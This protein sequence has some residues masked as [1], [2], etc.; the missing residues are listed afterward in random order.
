[1]TYLLG[2]DQGGTKTTAIVGD[3]SGHILGIGNSFGAVHS[4]HG[5][6]R[7]MEASKRA[8][9]EAMDSAGLTYDDIY[10]IYGGVS[11]MDWEYERALIENAMRETFPVK[12]IRVVNDCIIAMRSA[13]DSPRS[14]VICAGTGVNCAVRCGDREIVF[15]YYIPDSMQ[16]G[17]AI[18]L[19]AIQRVFDAEAGVGKKTLLTG[20]I[21]RHFGVSTVDRLLQK[22]VEKEITQ[23]ALT[24]LPRLV[25]E[26]ALEGDRVADQIYADFARGIVPYIHAGMR[27]LGMLEEPADVVLSGS[28]FK[29]RAAGLQETVRKCLL[30]KAPRVNVIDAE[31]EPIIGAYLLG[32]DDLPEI[33]FPD[34]YQNIKKEHGNYK[35]LR[36]EGGNH[37]KEDKEKNVDSGS[38]V[39]NGSRLSYNS[40][41]GSRS[42]DP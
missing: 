37:E 7:A 26:A 3:E 28:I 36:K 32:L 34:V 31:Y 16:G 12:R 23:I 14:A 17:A 15:G 24:E 6:P 42:D 41:Y 5:M 21:L 13:T 39:C 10:G 33:Y 8:C 4:V 29:C 25:E 22:Y 30:E 9:E 1:M 18:G 27:R 38:G 40:G 20:R 19:Q 2:I 11:G 35:I